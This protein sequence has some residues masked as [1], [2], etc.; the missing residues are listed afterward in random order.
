MFQHGGLE[1][2]V[3]DIHGNGLGTR[4][5]VREGCTLLSVQLP[6][7]DVP[8]DY[9]RTDGGYTCMGH[10]MHRDGAGALVIDPGKTIRGS[11][12]ACKAYMEIRLLRLLNHSFAPNAKIL[13][14]E[15]SGVPSWY[16]RAGDVEYKLWYNCS[17]IALSDIA[18][19]EE[20]TIEYADPPKGVK[21]QRRLHSGQK[22]R[23][24]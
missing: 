9:D 11:V 3:S 12:P 24:R 15:A 17:V 2:I 21:R 1:E 16:E 14:E 10:I 23:K 19:G 7:V 22:R 18:A 4:V 8:K 13:V 6:D 20:V 5:E